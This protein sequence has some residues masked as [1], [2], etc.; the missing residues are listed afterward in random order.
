MTRELQGM[1]QGSSEVRQAIEESLLTCRFF[2][3]AT[4]DHQKH[5]EI[6]LDHLLQKSAYRHDILG[7]I[8]IG[9]KTPE[10]HP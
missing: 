2:I 8:L 4:T 5:M 6:A 1:W 9:S 10:S 7:I 3:F